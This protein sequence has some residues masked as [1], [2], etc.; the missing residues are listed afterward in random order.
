MF[1]K[2]D[3]QKIITYD[4]ELEDFLPEYSL[5]RYNPLSK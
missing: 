4:F 1:Q 2:L 5:K 3:Y